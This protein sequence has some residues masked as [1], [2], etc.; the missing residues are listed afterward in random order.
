MTPT[1]IIINLLITIAM[2]FL[3]LLFAVTTGTHVESQGQVE[4]E[5]VNKPI[6]SPRWLPAEVFGA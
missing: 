4:V 5:L 6:L 3:V 2:L 1:I